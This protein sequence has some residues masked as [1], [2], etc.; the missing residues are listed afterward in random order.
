MSGMNWRA[1]KKR[2]PLAG[3]S[4]FCDVEPGGKAA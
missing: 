3:E 4:V 2:P 1:E